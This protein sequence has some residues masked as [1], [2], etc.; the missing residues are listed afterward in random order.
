MKITLPDGSARTFPGSVSGADVAKSISEGLFK[1]AL[2]VKVDG[3]LADL[4]SPITEDS[5]VEIITDRSPEALDVYRHSTAHLLASAVKELFPEAKIGIGPV[6]EDGFYYDFDRETPFTPDDLSVIENKMAEISKRAFPVERRELSWQEAR[7]L[8]EKEREPYKAELAYEKGQGGPVSI[9]VQGAFTDFCRGPHVPN[10]SKIKEGTYKLLSIA[11]AYWKGDEKNKMLQRIYGTSFLGK[12]ELDAHLKKIEEAK[13]RDHRKLGREL[14]LFSIADE[15]GGGLV[16]WHPKG[17]II[18]KTI[19]DFW[20]D[21][22]TR[23]GYDFVFSPHVGRST[24]WE[25]SGHLD[26]YKESMYPSM[27]MEHQTFYTKPMNCPFH[28]M[29]YRSRQRSYRDLP[30]RWAELGTVYRYEKSG[31]LHGLMRVRG[32]TQDD[33]HLFVPPEKMEEEVIGVINFTVHILRSF[34]FNEFTAYIATRPEKAVGEENRWN[35]AIN[36]LKRAADMANIS[37]QID[38]GGGAFYGPKIDIKIKDA[39][40]RSWQLSTVQFDFNLPERFGLEYVG[41]DNQ[42]HR[43]YMIHRAL[44]GSLERFFGILIENFAG[45]FPLWLAPEQARVLPIADRHIPH[46]QSVAERLRAEG[47]RAGVDAR[48]EKIN[49]KI[50]EAQLEKVPYMLV[51]GDKEQEN[52]TVSVR[53]RS[54]G[55]KGSFSLDSFLSD[56]KGRIKEKSLTLD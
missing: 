40:G 6:I 9:Y 31:V 37:Y 5:K 15:I 2:A 39:I 10:T 55:D 21:E 13:A 53:T 52:G 24:L 42:P 4:E 54:G 27:E 17:A 16:L 12:K 18:R 14:D 30:L 38:E 32:F 33:A 51:I 47:L 22:H 50:R 56:A 1:A 11:G 41:S 46:A 29:I 48:A 25:T 3:R 19:E 7:D 20:R 8:F 43:P 26:F 44:L 49:Y 35:D 36:A 23:N 34:G 45:A 28:V